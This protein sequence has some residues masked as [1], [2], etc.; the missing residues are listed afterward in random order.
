MKA[1]QVF[2]P[3]VIKVLDAKIPVIDLSLIH[4]SLSQFKK[5]AELQHITRAAEELHVAQPSLSR[6]IARL[7]QELGVPLFERS[8]KKMCIRDSPWP[9]Q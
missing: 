2:A 7:E 3:G 4:I 5:I 6:T 9:P 1:V 8:G